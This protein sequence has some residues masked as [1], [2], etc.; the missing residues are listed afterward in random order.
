M[1]QGATANPVKYLFQHMAM[2]DP[3][4]GGGAAGILGEICSWVCG[5]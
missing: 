3:G 2:L 4:L 5:V 1:L